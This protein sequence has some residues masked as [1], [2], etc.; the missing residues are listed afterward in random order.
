MSDFNKGSEASFFQRNKIAIIVAAVV[1]VAIIVGVVLYFVL[2]PKNFLVEFAAFVPAT[3]LVAKITNNTAEPVK[4]DWAFAA[5]KYKD[6][7]VDYSIK[8]GADVKSKEALT[9]D[10][11]SRVEDEKKKLPEE[12]QKLLKKQD[13]DADKKKAE[14]EKQQEEFKA[15]KDIKLDANVIVKYGKDGKDE[16]KW[17]DKIA[18]AAPEA[19]AKAASKS[20]AA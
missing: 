2:R 9:L 8:V 17:N 12:L 18:V 15:G 19:A 14:I 1:V 4:V 3:G 16:F 5:V 7:V 6:Y 11:A 20:K 13:E 10:K